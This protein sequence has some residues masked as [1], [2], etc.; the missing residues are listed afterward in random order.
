[1][2][3]RDAETHKGKQTIIKKEFLIVPFNVLIQLTYSDITD[4]SDIGQTAGNITKFNADIDHMLS[5][6]FFSK[7]IPWLEIDIIFFFLV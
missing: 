4:C 5:T 1:M 3:F 2:L 7:I 6:S